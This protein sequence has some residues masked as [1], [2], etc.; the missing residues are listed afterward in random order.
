[1]FL[2]YGNRWR[3]TQ[4]DQL[5]SSGCVCLMRQAPT[6]VPQPPHHVVL[7]QE[8]QALVAAAGNVSAQRVSMEIL[9]AM[10]VEFSITSASPLGLPWD[11][12]DKAC[13]YVAAMDWSHSAAV[14]DG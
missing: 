8:M 13:R 6:L 2:W 1:M 12:H 3:L 7:S 5:V 4:R 10:V 9:Q 11:Y 14:S